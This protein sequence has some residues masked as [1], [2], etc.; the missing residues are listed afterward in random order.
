MDKETYQ[1]TCLLRRESRM[2]TKLQPWWFS[3]RMST[4]TGQ[5]QRN[6]TDERSIV[7]GKFFNQPSNRSVLDLLAL[8][9]NIT[10]VSQNL[11]KLDE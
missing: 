10:E 4:E 8:A 6:S 1:I 2:N 11:T 3:L 5:Q 7:S 9:A